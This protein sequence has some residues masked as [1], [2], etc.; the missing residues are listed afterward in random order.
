M[1]HKLF[2]IAAYLA[3]IPASRAIGI[4]FHGAMPSAVFHDLAGMDAAE[5]LDVLR[6][7]LRDVSKFAEQLISPAFETE[8]RRNGILEVKKTSGSTFH[9]LMLRPRFEIQDTKEGFMLIGTFP[10][11]KKEDISLEVVENQ[12]GRFLE[13]AGGSQQ[14]PSRSPSPSRGEKIT[15]QAPKLRAGYAKFERRVKIP[16]NIDPSTLQAKYE[17]GLLV[18]TIYPLAKKDTSQRQKISIS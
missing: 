12:E 6:E 2:L 4:S 8:Q 11:L 17:D 9:E 13:V 5:N 15:I 3:T 16:Q 7:S 18:V 14:V 10:G 1:V